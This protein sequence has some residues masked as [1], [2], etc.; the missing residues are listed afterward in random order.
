[1][2]PQATQKFLRP[3]IGP[4]SGLPSGAK[5]NGP[6]TTLRMPTSAKRR[7]VLE[8]DLQ[9]RRNA[10]QVIRQQALGEV[11][12][13]LPR[14]PG[15]AGALVGPE[16]HAA[17]LLAHV[18]LALEVDAVQLLLAALQLRQVLGDQ[19]LVLHGEDRQFQSDHAPDF[20][21]PQTA[22]VH[23]VLGVHVALLGDDVPGAIAR[24]A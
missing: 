18:D 17:A 22:G 13:R 7:E 20:A 14:R 5:V 12:G 16:Q 8:A 10:L 21:R 2:T 23:H 4:T 9:A 11:P 24:A 3:R 19:V 1:M 15:H 6:L